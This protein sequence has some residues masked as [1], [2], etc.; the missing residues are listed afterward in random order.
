V[1]NK[2]ISDYPLY[3]RNPYDPE[4]I[5]E[6]IKQIG[7][8]EQLVYNEDG[9]AFVLKPALKIK[10][11]FMKDFKPYR[12]LYTDHIDK[13]KNL[14]TPGLRM[15][16]FILMSIDRDVDVIRIDPRKAVSFCEYQSM[17]QYYSG[18][19]DLLQNDFIVRMSDD[20]MC[21]Y[22]N[23]NIFFNGDRGKLLDKS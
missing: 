7:G 13:I 21:F 5:Y 14:S 4:G 9:D 18:I 17:N 6:R 12:K 3:D 1:E 20:R 10:G 15:F 22:I 2:K 8:H 11:K 19:T 16:C 23:V